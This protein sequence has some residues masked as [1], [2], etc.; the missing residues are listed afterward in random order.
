M[1]IIAR[2]ECIVNIRDEKNKLIKNFKVL[3]PSDYFGEISLIYGCKRTAT[4]VSRKYTTLAK[5]TKDIYTEINTEFPKIREILKKGI[6]KYS[7]RMKRFIKTCL[8]KVEYFAEA[9]DDAMHDL[10]YA[11]SLR[12]WQEGEIIFT[13]GSE[14]KTLYFIMNGVVEIYCEF[15]G[16]VF[17]IEN[18]YSGSIINYRNWFI[19]EHNMVSARFQGTGILLELNINTFNK[20]AAHHKAELEDKFLRYQNKIAKENK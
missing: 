3:G 2:G 16:H 17:I 4:I 18:L 15:E 13:P 1:Y 11:F 12:H 8:K 10:M 5:L 19:D 7:D 20:V 14:T 6:F 9:K